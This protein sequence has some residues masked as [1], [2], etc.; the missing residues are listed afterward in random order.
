MKEYRVRDGKHDF[1]PV[2]GTGIIGWWKREFNFKVVFTD[3]CR[4]ILEQGDQ[5]S[6][7]K[8]GGISFCIA[9]K[10]KKSV[11][12]AWRYNPALG[13]IELSPYYH[14]KGEVHYAETLRQQP[15]QVEIG[16]VVYVRIFKRRSEWI[17]DIEAGAKGWIEPTGLTGWPL[18]TIGL[19][20]GG[21]MPAPQNMN[22]FLKKY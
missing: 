21:K 20:F 6:W 17:V 13:V 12:W 14:H 2:D 5:K 4:Y 19:W 10:K 16:E 7:N 18:V 9:S 1:R 15:I 22:L 11:M 8:G 3:S